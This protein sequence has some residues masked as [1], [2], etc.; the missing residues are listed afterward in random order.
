[1]A[2]KLVI[3]D[4]EMHILH[5]L[6]LKLRNAGYEVFTAGDGEEAL[7]LCRSESPDMIIADYQMPYRNGLELC[8]AYRE[9]MGFPI[10]AILLTAREHDIRACDMQSMGVDMVMAKPFSPREVLQAVATLLE[11]SKHI[12]AA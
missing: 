8:A 5:V 1:M 9:M 4:D 6:A 12:D 2:K 3:A 10:P 11:E 7:Q